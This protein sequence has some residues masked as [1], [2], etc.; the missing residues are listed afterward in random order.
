MIKPYPDYLHNGTAFD[1]RF[2]VTFDGEKE[3]PVSR[4]GIVV[5]YIFAAVGGAIVTLGIVFILGLL[6][7]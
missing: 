6:R 2:D 3:V 1:D 7:G 5:V 4:S